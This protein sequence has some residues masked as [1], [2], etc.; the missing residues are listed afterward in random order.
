MGKNDSAIEV[1]LFQNQAASSFGRRFAY[2]EASS[3]GR[4]FKKQVAQSSSATVR[5]FDVMP[6]TF[7]NTKDELLALIGFITSATGTSLPDTH[8]PATPID[9]SLILGIKPTLSSASN[10][11]EFLKNEVNTQTPLVLFGRLR[12]PWHAEAAK[13][14]RRFCTSPEPVVIDVD[15]RPDSDVFIPTLARLLGSSDLP[16][17]LFLS[18]SLGDVH[19]VLALSDVEF[20][21]RLSASNVISVLA[22]KG[23]YTGKK[24]GHDRDRMLRPAA[25]V[26]EQ[27]GCSYRDEVIALGQH[28]SSQST[29]VRSR[30]RRRVWH[31]IGTYQW[32]KAEGICPVPCYFFQLR[33]A[34]IDKA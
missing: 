2:D 31:D 33:F 9:P 12:D 25:I 6:Y 13:L 22:E 28:F 21:K 17:L 14:L 15:Q 26:V 7:E 32:K 5:P 18:E 24:D 10:D 23:M 1:A 19:D 3:Y 30:G 16:Q 27:T 4:G 20:E 29:F 8:D 34:G 11:L